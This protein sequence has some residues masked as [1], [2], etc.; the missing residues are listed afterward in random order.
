MP[1]E[2]IFLNQSDDSIGLKLKNIKIT[3]DTRKKQC[4]IIVRYLIK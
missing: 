3:I 1:L 4:I 2:S